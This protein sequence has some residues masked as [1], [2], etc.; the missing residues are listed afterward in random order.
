MKPAPLP[1]ERHIEKSKLVEYLLHPVNSRGKLG[2]FSR[3]GFNQGNWEG[4]RDS[5]LRHAQE[6]LVSAVVASQY[7]T[8]YIVTGAL[9]TPS[10]RKP[11]PVV[12]AVWQQDTGETGVRFITAYPT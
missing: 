3:Y 7:G 1:K 12:T 9:N 11:S 5:L 8:K 6:N 2:H 4:L 10:G